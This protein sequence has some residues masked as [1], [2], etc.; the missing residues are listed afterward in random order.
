MLSVRQLKKEKIL[1][2]II[3]VIFV[4]LSSIIFAIFSMTSS[5]ISNRVY[6]NNINVSNKSIKEAKKILSS[7]ICSSTSLHLTYEDFETTI[8]PS[9]FDFSFDINST[10]QE[11]YL[12]GKSNNVFFNYFQIVSSIFT[13]YNISIKY[14]YNQEKLDYI[15]DNINLNLPGIMAEPS[16]YIENNSLI[17]CK[18]TDGITLCKE[19]LKKIILD[20]LC[21]SNST[22]TVNLTI[23]VKFAFSSQINIEKIYNEIH[24]EAQNAFIEKNPFDFHM[25]VDGVDFSISMEEAKSLLQKNSN[26]YIIP[27]TITKP[28]ITINDLDKDI[29][30]NC[31]S[32]YTSNYNVGN[33]NRSNNVEIA[34]RKLNNIIVLPR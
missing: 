14:N 5:K 11:A 2:V 31:L 13:P 32:N 22:N 8:F 19:E 27:L 18:G 1:L 21:N 9:E 23:P 6:I 28:E 24:C 4:L 15:L 16:Y 30:V 17:I 10:I 29:F 25:N 26:R 33:A 7:K 3:I 34:T 20:T 12:I